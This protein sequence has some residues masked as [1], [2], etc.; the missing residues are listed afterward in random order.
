MTLFLSAIS[1]SLQAQ[2]LTSFADPVGTTQPKINS[3]LETNNGALV[4]G[5]FTSIVSRGGTL[6]ADSIN[7]IAIADMNGE[8]SRLGNGIP[9]EV[10]FTTQTDDG[11]YWAITDSTLWKYVNSDW[12]QMPVYI[13]TGN[14]K[15]CFGTKTND[16]ILLGNLSSVSGVNC[17]N[18]IRFTTSNQSFDTTGLNIALGNVIQ[19]YDEGNFVT[20]TENDSVVYFT[21]QDFFTSNNMCLYKYDLYTD[22]ASLIPNAP[23]M[24]IPRVLEWSADKNSLYY[25]GLEDANRFLYELSSAGQW[26]QLFQIDQDIISMTAHDNN[27][28]IS[29]FFHQIAGLSIES[30]AILNELTS[31][32]TAWN[33]NPEGLGSVENL[34]FFQNGKILGKTSFTLIGNF[35]TTGIDHFESTN[36][37]SL[38]PNP[39]L[40]QLTIKTD[41]PTKTDYT[42]YDVTG[43]IMNTGRFNQNT[44]ISISDFAQGNYFIQLTTN[45]TTTTQKFIKQ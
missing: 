17:Q 33:M 41:N 22:K 7:N 27:V 23:F 32:V 16:I 12:E 11:T 43:R 39:T 19:Q 10:I 20:L 14:L 44:T 25:F 15:K 40:T 8:I 31:T 6:L 3:L 38:S 5:S 37:F 13:T 24:L 26:S 45:Q 1:F 2:T 35:P 36:S 42:I 29:G 9:Y 28:Y 21:W 4:A 34:V 30:N 18:I